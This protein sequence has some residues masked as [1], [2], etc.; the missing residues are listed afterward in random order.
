[1]K[2]KYQ[3]PEAEIISFNTQ[4]IMTTEGNDGDLEDVSTPDGFEE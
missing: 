2:R 3:K 1:M 4:I